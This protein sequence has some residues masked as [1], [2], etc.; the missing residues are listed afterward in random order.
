MGDWNHS[1]RN[2]GRT[3][4]PSPG[5]LSTCVVL[6]VC[7]WQEAPKSSS[8]L[9][10][11]S[12]FCPQCLK[13]L[14][15]G[16]VAVCDIN[17]SFPGILDHKGLNQLWLQGFLSSGSAPFRAVPQPDPSPTWGT[18]SASWGCH[19]AA[20]WESCWRPAYTG[21]VGGKWLVTLHAPTGLTA[22]THSGTEDYKDD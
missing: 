7:A 8:V 11:L 2:L 10:I 22:L 4:I 21:T 3:E 15:A 9:S 19:G 16:S 6:T 18:I 17:S 1:I 5:L 13:G 20:A 14:F 12:V